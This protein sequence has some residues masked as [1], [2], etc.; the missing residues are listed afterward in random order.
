MLGSELCKPGHK[1]LASDLY[2]SNKR[3]SCISSR[4]IDENSSKLKYILICTINHFN[5]IF[6]N[7]KPFCEL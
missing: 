1:A 3:M 5:S 2:F 7:L 4:E 6:I